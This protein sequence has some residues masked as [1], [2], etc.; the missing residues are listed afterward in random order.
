M[1]KRGTRGLVVP[2]LLA[3]ALVAACGKK[4]AAPA[5]GAAG[6]SGAAPAAGAVTANPVDAA[7]AGSIHGTVKFTGTAPKVETIDMSSEPE[8]AKARTTPATKEDVVVANGALANVF[9]Y[10]KDGLDKTLKFPAG[11][12]V[13]IDQQGCQYHP[14]VIAMSVG[15]TLNVKNSDPFLHNI[16][17]QPKDNRGFNRSQP[18]QGMEFQ[19]QFTTPEVMI[20]VKCDVH[21]WM[22]AFIGVTDNPYHAVSGADGTFTLDRLPPGKYTLEAWH[23]KYGTATQEVTV[24]TGKPTEVTFTFDGKKTAMVPMGPTLVIDHMTGAMHREAPAPVT[25]Q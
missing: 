6:A 10:V 22:S 12:P 18:N 17:A 9:V 20:P 14:H 15:Q 8:C 7:T 1:E 3:L 13:T 4:E 23:E 11:D 2:S 25:Q 16:N 24:E 5:A 21:G 19:T